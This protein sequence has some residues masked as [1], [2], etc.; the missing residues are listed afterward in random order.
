MAARQRFQNIETAENAHKPAVIIDHRQALYIPFPHQ[1]S[2]LAER[3]CWA[4][5]HRLTRHYLRNDPVVL[6]EPR[7]QLACETRIRHAL[8]ADADLHPTTLQQ[9][10]VTDDSDKS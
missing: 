8:E 2:S 6:T 4:Y 5:G 1:T 10:G 9:I 3:S 7:D